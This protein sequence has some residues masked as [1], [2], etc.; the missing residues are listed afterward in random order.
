MISHSQYF[1]IYLKKVIQLIIIMKNVHLYF[2]KKNLDDQPVSL[3]LILINLS[4]I[5]MQ[6]VMILFTLKI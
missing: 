3:Y 4:L 1:K 2:L 6:K 5:M